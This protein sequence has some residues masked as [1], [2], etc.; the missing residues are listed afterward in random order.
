[1]ARTILLI[2]GDQ[3]LHRGCA[4]VEI[5]TKWDDENHLL[6]SNAEEAWEVVEGSIKKVLNHFDEH[7]YI[8]CL[9]DC[10]TVD[11]RKQIDPSYKANRAGTRKP[12]CF[13]DIKAKLKREMPC[14]YLTGLEADDVMG[15]LATK[16]GPD[17]KI[18]VSRDKD[19]RTIPAMVWDGQ[20]FYNITEAQADYQHL[21]Q[22]LVGDASDGY[23]G[24]PGV[25][26]KTAEKLLEKYKEVE[27][28]SSLWTMVV[29]A[30]EKAGLTEEDA[31]RQA[32]LARILRWRDWDSVK[33]EPILWT[34]N[35]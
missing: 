19:M 7:D 35:S 1:M 4:A 6:H 28:V 2:D 22:T 9:S 20:R 29:F 27:A 26:P 24:C 12:L 25:G 31:L 33:K 8:I 23:K 16:P 32:R 10:D 34:P 15:I 30:F 5:D 18:I 11:Y 14:R 21:F 17:K 3:Y 13:F